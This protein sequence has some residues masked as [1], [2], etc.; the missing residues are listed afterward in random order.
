MSAES[1]VASALSFLE[2]MV[3]CRVARN[4]GL[5]AKRAPLERAI[6]TFFIRWTLDWIIPTLHTINYYSTLL[7]ATN[8]SV[9]ANRRTLKEAYMAAYKK[10]ALCREEVSP[11]GV[12]GLSISLMPREVSN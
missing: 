9:L 4:F 10:E 6:A 12:R 11:V 7:L 8:K 1:S 3:A 5:Q 2:R